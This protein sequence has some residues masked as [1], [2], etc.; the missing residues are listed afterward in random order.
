MIDPAE[1]LRRTLE[2]AVRTMVGFLEPYKDDAR[3]VWKPK[4]WQE[5][6]KKIMEEYKLDEKDARVLT[7]LAVIAYN[8]G[9]GDALAGMILMQL[10][11]LN[12]IQDLIQKLTGKKPRTRT[13]IFLSLDDLGIIR[14]VEKVLRGLGRA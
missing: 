1:E 11:N 4:E 7:V 3:E 12:T 6:I 9:E 5:Y 2:K 13:D 14:K 10:V 8:Y